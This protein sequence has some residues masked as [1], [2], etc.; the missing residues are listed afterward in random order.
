MSADEKG[1]VFRRAIS[2]Q[3]DVYTDKRTPPRG[4]E[5]APEPV[6]DDI[7]GKYSGD[8]LVRARSRRPTPER[9]RILETKHD[10][11]NEDVTEIRVG[12]SKMSGQMDVL[13]KHILPA[14]VEEQKTERTRLTTSSKVAIAALGFLGSLVTAYLMGGCSYP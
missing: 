6:F 5:S 12:V 11:L 9:L 1:P 7:T 14:Q 3:R 10:A 8:D 4:V 13:L 2:H